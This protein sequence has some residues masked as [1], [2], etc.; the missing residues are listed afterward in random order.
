MGCGVEVLMFVSVSHDAQKR[1]NNMMAQY[2]SRKGESRTARETKSSPV[3][4]LCY[5]GQSLAPIKKT[6]FFVWK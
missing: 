5:R 2:G 6:V 1:E 4:M 3:L